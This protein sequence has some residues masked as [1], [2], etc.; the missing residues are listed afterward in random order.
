MTNLCTIADDLYMHS[1]FMGYPMS[2]KSMAFIP[3]IVGFVT[4]LTLIAL[5]GRVSKDENRTGGA[6][7]PDGAG[8]DQR[9][10]HSSPPTDGGSCSSSGG[11]DKKESIS[12]T[13]LVKAEEKGS[14]CAKPSRQSSTDSKEPLSQKE[15]C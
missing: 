4:F 6:T 10:Q 1:R 3:C 2:V 14:S 7:A 9:S 12:M 15:G 11:S 8:G 13:R 5:Y